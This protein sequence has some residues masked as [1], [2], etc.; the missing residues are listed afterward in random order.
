MTFDGIKEAYTATELLKNDYTQGVK[1]KLQRGFHPKRSGDVFVIYEPGWFPTS[2]GNKGTNHGTGY[3]YDTHV[4]LLIYGKNIKAQKSVNYHEIIDIIPTICLKYEFK[5]PNAST[6][7]P[8]L[9]LF[10]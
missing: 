10:D 7:K 4:P 5:L 9:E 6:G 8:I 2:Y 1:A 3:P